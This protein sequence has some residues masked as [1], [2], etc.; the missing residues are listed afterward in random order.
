MLLSLQ[1]G[2]STPRTSAPK[3]ALTLRHKMKA[4]YFS[5]DLTQL[6]LYNLYG[7]NNIPH[8]FKCSFLIPH[9]D[10]YLGCWI[11]L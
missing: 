11:V 5:E 7:Y 6:L 8:I 1:E 2:G 3:E 9:S 10:F 4:Y